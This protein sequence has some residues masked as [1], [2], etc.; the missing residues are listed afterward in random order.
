MAKQQTAAYMFV[1]ALLSPL[2]LIGHVRSQYGRN[3]S[4]T[5]LYSCHSAMQHAGISWRASFFGWLKL[6]I[7]LAPAVCYHISMTIFFRECRWRFVIKGKQVKF[8]LL[9]VIQGTF[10]KFRPRSCYTLTMLRLTLR[11]LP[12]RINVNSISFRRGLPL[13]CSGIWPLK[14]VN[15]SS[16]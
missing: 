10:L 3:H 16:A 15:N 8:L 4:E 11:V 6:I 7:L 13:F 14:S 12:I 9:F 2:R 5:F 1:K